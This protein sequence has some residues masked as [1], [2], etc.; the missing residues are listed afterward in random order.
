LL[1]WRAAIKYPFHVVSVALAAGIPAARD[2][3][4]FDSEKDQTEY[5]EDL[6]RWMDRD[7]KDLGDQHYVMV[8]LKR[9]GDLDDT[10]DEKLLSNLVITDFV[11]K[12]GEKAVN[13]AVTATLQGADW[14]K[15]V[16]PNAAAGDAEK[17][18]KAEAKAAAK[19]AKVKVQ[20][21]VPAKGLKAEDAPKPKAKPVENPVGAK[22]DEPAK[23]VRKR[24]A[25]VAG[26]K[27]KEADKADVIK[28]M[29]ERAAARAAAKA[30]APKPAIQPDNAAQP[31][32][33]AEDPVVALAR[34]R[35]RKARQQVVIPY[36]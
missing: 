16:F 36:P 26:T 22:A 17:Q 31:F 9:D 15:W 13:E 4:R 11:L 3:A 18:A 8:S 29:E 20:K 7:L 25:K 21:P 19:A 1:Q 27:I 2:Y 5:V 10:T 30:A 28:R 6:G 35:N 23:A 34:P 32:V 24:P 12:G 14:R 33:A